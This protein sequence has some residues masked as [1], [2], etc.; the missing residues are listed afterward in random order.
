[1]PVGFLL[2]AFASIPIID[3][4]NSWMLEQ[5]MATSI[6]IGKVTVFLL[7][8]FFCI[9]SM[10]LIPRGVAAPPIP[11]KFAEM[12]IETSSRLSAERLFLPKSLVIIGDK[13]LDNFLESPLC[14]KIENKPIQMA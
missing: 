6:I 7:V 12:F 5:L 8:L 9:D 4:G 13:N 3:V 10:A 14:S 2:P 11:S 1:M